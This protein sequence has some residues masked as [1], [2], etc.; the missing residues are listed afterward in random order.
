MSSTA[1]WEE[2]KRLAADFQRVQLVESSYKLSERNC[3]EIINKLVELGMI[4]LYHSI[5]GKEFITHKHLEKE[6]YDEIYVHEGRI[7]I[8]ELQKL[9]NV[10]ISHIESKVSEVVKN[11]PDLNL[12]LGQIISKDYMNKISE[13][14]NELLNERGSVSISELTNIYNLPTD[15]LQQIIKPRVGTIIK[16]NFDGNILYTLNYVNTQKALLSGLLEASIKPIRFAQLTKEFNLD[17][18]MIFD[19]FDE[20]ISSGQI[21]GSLYGGRQVATAVFVPQIFIKAQEQYVLSF[22]KQNGYIDYS[23]LKKIGI[24]EPDSYIRSLLSGQDVRYLNSSCLANYFIDQ[25]EQEIEEILNKNGYCDLTQTLP[26]ILSSKDVGMLTV[27]FQEKFKQNFE[28][29]VMAETYLLSKNFMDK[30]KTKFYDQMEE[31]SKDDLTKPNYVLA[32]KSENVVVGSFDGK[33]TSGSTKSAKSKS[34]KGAQVES[35]NLAVEITF[36]DKTNL[37]KELKSLVEDINDDLLDSLVEQFLKPLNSQ[38]LDLLKSKVEKGLVASSKDNLPENGKHVSKK[39]TIKD[40]QEKARLFLV[41]GRLFEKALKLFTDAKVQETL[42]KH[43]VKTSCSE[44]TNEMLKFIAT[45]QMLQI[46]DENLNPDSRSKLIQKLKDPFK[47]KFTELNQALANK[48]CSEVIDLIEKVAIEALELS[49]KKDQKREKEV[50]LQLRESTKES[51]NEEK[52]PATVL[53]LVCLL[54]FYFS[55]NQ[56]LNAPGRCVPNILEFLRTNLIDETYTKLIYF[57]NVIIENVTKGKANEE[58][59]VI[60]D[61]LVNEVKTIAMRPKEHLKETKN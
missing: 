7:N 1:T 31:K 23:T 6:I 42:N 61:E 44:I 3:I 58:S 14:I 39:L 21:K 32:I 55:T 52:D 5:D 40:V 24:T 45:E 57:Q 51:L 48:S 29:I 11:D 20:L 26:S 2:I 54:L 47:H 46:N 30:I 59:N 37:I 41:Q 35:E 33:S 13:E 25:T 10:D 12:I 49:I 22:F 15:Y 8:V 19:I 60:T 34:K 56:F 18:G 27:T 50:L 28:T 43:L 36:I 17:S 16:G 53:H 4:N 9:L 38:Y